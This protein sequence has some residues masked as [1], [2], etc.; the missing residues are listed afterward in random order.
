MNTDIFT[1][2]YAYLWTPFPY[3]DPERMVVLAQ[4][5][6]AQVLDRMAV[7][8]PDVEDWRKAAGRASIAAYTHKGFVLNSGAEP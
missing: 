2:L 3:P 7:S 8:Y 5:N 4:M 1:A 6:P